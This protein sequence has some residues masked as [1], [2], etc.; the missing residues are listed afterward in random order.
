MTG[1]TTTDVTT[2]PRMNTTGE[3]ERG[4]IVIVIADG[5]RDLLSEDE[6][7]GATTLLHALRPL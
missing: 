7:V 1:T 3:K 2:A 4:D 5:G 6:I